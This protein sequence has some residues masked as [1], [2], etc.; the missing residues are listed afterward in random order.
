MKTKLKILAG[1]ILASPLILSAL[2]A[3]AILDDLA[4]RA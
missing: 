3:I 1:V 2:T 4:I